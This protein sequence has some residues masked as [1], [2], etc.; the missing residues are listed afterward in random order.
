[1]FDLMYGAG[2]RHKEC[3][4]LRVKDLCFES[5]SIVVRNGKGAKDRVTVLPQRCVPDLKKQIE[6]VERLHE[7]DLAEGFCDVYLPHALSRKYPNAGQQ[8]CWKWLFPSRQHSQDRR[9]GKVWR[10]H[11][12]EEVFQS[13]FRQAVRLAKINKHAVP[14]TLRHSFAT[15]LLEGGSDIR[16]VQEL[17]G[18]KDVK[19]TMIYTHVMNRPGISVRSPIDRIEDDRDNIAS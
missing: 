18:H 9:S 2:L 12:S 13:A 15:H 8:L 19:T 17:L 5:G 6:H 1:M 4:S 14:H 7:H 16:T 3:R 11:L 10:F